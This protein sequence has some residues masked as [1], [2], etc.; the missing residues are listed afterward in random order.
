MAGRR[1]GGG[2]WWVLVSES[3][4]RGPPLSTFPG[5]ILSVVSAHFCRDA[6]E[7][8]W[9]PV[10][11]AR[12]DGTATFLEKSGPRLEA[13]LGHRRALRSWAGPCRHRAEQRAPHCVP[14][15]RCGG[16]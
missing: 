6:V 14:A 2:V 1:T 9:Q 12:I 15:A 10:L 5:V 16:L 8:S 4:S 7:G 13:N 3:S 11:P